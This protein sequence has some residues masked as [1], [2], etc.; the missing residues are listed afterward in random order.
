MTDNKR[1]DPRGNTNANP[2]FL[3]NSFGVH[4]HNNFQNQNIISNS[5]F[6][7][8]NFLNRKRGIDR[9]ELP[10]I[11]QKISNRSNEIINF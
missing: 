4:F 9:E 7:N 6:H 2:A 8:P 5:S 3:P 10:E 1:N 11:D